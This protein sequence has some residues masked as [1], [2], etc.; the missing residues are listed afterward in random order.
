[1]KTLK[2]LALVAIV[3]IMAA[4][5]SNGKYTVSLDLTA[6]DS[7]DVSVDSVKLYVDSNLVAS[8]F[9]AQDGKVQLTGTLEEPVIAELRLYFR[10]MGEPQEVPTS[11]ILEEGEIVLNVA[12]GAFRG[13]PQNE[14]IYAFF[15]GLSNVA[16][17]EEASASLDTFVVAHKGELC[18]AALLTSS[19]ISSIASEES[20]LKAIATLTDSQKQLPGIVALVEKMEKASAS[21]EGKMFVDF[22][23]EYEGNMQH[24]SD[25]VGKGKYVLVDF[26]ASW[27]GPCRQEIPN[28]IAVH[29]QYAG[30]KLQVIGVATWDEPND[31]KE[32]I[33]E[34]GI[35][36]EQIMNAQKA[37]SDAYSIEG[38]PE[39]ILFGPDGTILKRGLR[40]EDIEKAV[41]ECLG[42]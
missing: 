15:E 4:C 8:T 42:L 2:H 33:E 6:W 29:N 35:P 27:C 16:D 18:V 20:I 30:D 34:L 21:A 11:F 9:L 28:L 24:L 25:Y 1:M 19:G 41:K 17:R 38:I 40:G 26:W 39:I 14:A 36:Y 32:A 5:T 3:A 31:T 22:E 7:L 12:D 23:A 37:G 10:W 13:T